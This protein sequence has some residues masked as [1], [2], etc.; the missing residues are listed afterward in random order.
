M[1]Y[2]TRI[3]AVVY[4]P[5]KVA[6]MKAIHNSCRTQFFDTIVVYDPAKVAKMKA[7]H[8]YTINAFISHFTNNC[9]CLCKVNNYIKKFC[10]L[11]KK[12]YVCNE[13]INQ[14]II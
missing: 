14:S 12:N 9:L 8:N 5:A 6:K 1:C 3:S 4:D 2:F 11:I 7:I 10:S 13:I